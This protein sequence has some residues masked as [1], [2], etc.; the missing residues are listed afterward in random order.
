MTLNPEALRDFL[1]E[2]NPDAL[3]LGTGTEFDPALLG[4]AE[5]DGTTVAVYGRE[6]IVACLIV[7]G[8]E[9]EDAEEWCAYDIEGSY[10]G[11]NAPIIV[12]TLF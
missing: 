3:L 2:A 11:E 9:S 8:M 12:S 7:S 1:S 6:R 5:R 10:M 4:T